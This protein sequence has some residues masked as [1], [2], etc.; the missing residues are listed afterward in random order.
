MIA[1]GVTLREYAASFNA[2]CPHQGIGQAIPERAVQGKGSVHL[3]TVS[4]WPLTVIRGPGAR[5]GDRRARV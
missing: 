3:I 2:A 5:A 1:A 4:A